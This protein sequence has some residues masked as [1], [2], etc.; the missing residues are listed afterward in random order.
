MNIAIFG[1][2]HQGVVMASCL[3]NFHNVD[4]FDTNAKNIDMLL[5]GKLPVNEPGLQKIFNKFYLNS[6]LKIHKKIQNF[7]SYDCIIIAHDTI[8]DNNDNS[9]FNEIIKTSKIINKLKIKKNCVLINFTQSPVG[10]TEKLFGKFKPC[11]I[12]ENLQLGTAIHDFLNPRLPI[13]GCDS[14]I[15]LKKIN[16]IFGHKINWQ[17]TGVKEAEFIKNC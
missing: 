8:V 13:I 16:N 17:I 1:L 7:K 5:E 6:K 15:D 11:Y 9:K 14:K 2:W 12:P 4:C 3:A 10:L